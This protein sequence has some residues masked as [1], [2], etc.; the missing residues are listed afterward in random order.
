M[1]RTPRPS[2][3]KDRYDGMTSSARLEISGIFG[4]H[5][6]IKNLEKICQTPPQRMEDFSDSPYHAVKFQTPPQNC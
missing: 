4:L 1:R 6:G 3:I 5:M 2:P